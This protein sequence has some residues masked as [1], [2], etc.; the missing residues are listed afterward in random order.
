MLR[1]RNLYATGIIIGLRIGRRSRY[2]HPIPMA[3]A[4]C[5]CMTIGVTLMTRISRA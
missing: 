3:A 4:D 2:L 5:Q 1:A